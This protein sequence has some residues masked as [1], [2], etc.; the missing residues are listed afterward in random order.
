[1][2][3]LASFRLLVHT[4]VPDDRVEKRAF[5]TLIVYVCLWGGGKDG[6]PH[7]CNNIVTPRHLLVRFSSTDELYIHHLFSESERYFKQRKKPSKGVYQP[8]SGKDLAHFMSLRAKDDL[9]ITVYQI[10]R[11]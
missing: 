1:M 11:F 10:F 3:P 7:V 9:H 4:L 2:L 8:W 5:L 6:G